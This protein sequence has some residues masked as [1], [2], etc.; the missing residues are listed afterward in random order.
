MKTEQEERK[1]DWFLFH[2][3]ASIEKV[4]H[5]Q[6][7][8]H[9][10]S[11]RRIRIWSRGAL[12][13]GLLIGCF[14]MLDLI[15]DL[16]TMKGRA[17]RH[18]CPKNLATTPVFMKGLL[19]SNRRVSRIDRY[20]NGNG[21]ISGDD[22]RAEEESATLSISEFCRPPPGRSPSLQEMFQPNARLPLRQKVN[23]VSAERIEVIFTYTRR[24][25]RREA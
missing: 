10:R 9:L 20:S 2:H 12:T 11:G 18:S 15:L 17:L 19:D 1:K 13:A 24:A 8:N 25:E 6:G 7:I 5:T 23:A 4:T 22:I 14:L 21:K 3:V 16:P